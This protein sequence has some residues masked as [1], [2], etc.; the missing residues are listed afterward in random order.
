MIFYTTSNKVRFPIQTDDDDV[1]LWM[2]EKHVKKNKL[3]K[4]DRQ[5]GGINNV[6]FS[7]EI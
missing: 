6:L 3:Q 5:K 7:K 2:P 4:K 1:A